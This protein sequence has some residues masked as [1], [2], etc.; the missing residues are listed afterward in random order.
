MNLL[1]IHN[2]ILQHLLQQGEPA[3]PDEKTCKYR[4][5][6]DGKTLMCAVGCLVTDEAYNPEM[7]GGGAGNSEVIEA[8]EKSSIPTDSET[9]SLLSTWQQ[10]HDGYRNSFV[11]NQMHYGAPLD[12][13]SAYINF[14]A[15]RIANKYSLTPKEPT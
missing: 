7:E 3:S 12:D 1:E 2:K 6:K 9:I 4:M 14:L 13:W 5:T 10:A 15:T 11:R 8:L